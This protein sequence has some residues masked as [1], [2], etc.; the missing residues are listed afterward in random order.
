MSCI[1]YKSDKPPGDEAAREP[2]REAGDPLD[3][4][5]VN[6][7]A[8]K[9]VKVG[10]VTEPSMATLE[11]MS[12]DE[13]A[14]VHG[15]A[16]ERPDFGRVEWLGRVDVRGVDLD[17]DVRICERDGP[18]EVEVYDDG[19]AL[20]LGGGKG[21]DQHL[22][23]WRGSSCHGG[24]GVPGLYLVVRGVLSCASL[25]TPRSVQPPPLPA[26]S[27]ALVSPAGPLAPPRDFVARVLQET[28][29]TIDDYLEIGEDNVRAPVCVRP[30]CVPCERR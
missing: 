18:P 3:D 16:V 14:A 11:K 23:R 24:R 28:R 12:D 13:L 17:R 26:T 30:C 4:D 8:P 5:D 10:F 19:D 7:N 2:S 20:D 25:A 22:E 6:P 29:P 1:R 9:L 21:G 15:F 27:R